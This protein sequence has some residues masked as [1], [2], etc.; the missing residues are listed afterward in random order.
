MKNQPKILDTF[1]IIGFAI[2]I[3]VSIGLILAKQNTISSVT[4]GFILAIFTQLFNLQIRHGDTEQ[5]LLRANLLSQ[6]LYQDEWLFS[7]L[8]QIVENYQLVRNGWFDFFR[9]R[10]KD[11]VVECRNLLHAMAEGYM[12]AHPRSPVDFGTEAAQMAEK[13]YKGTDTGDLEYWRS[14]HGERFFQSNLADAQRGVQVMRIFLQ[15]IDE[16]RKNIDLLEKQQAAGIEVRVAS[17]DELP[18]ELVQDY[19]IVDDRIFSVMT[20]SHDGF[21][22]EERISIDQV[23]VQGFVKK[24]D[25]LF[26]HSKS[27]DDAIDNLRLSS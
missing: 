3:T 26:Q 7:H 20:F 24:F 4:L 25:L 12:M 6:Q 16:L 8:Q 22:Q 18:P 27:L 19:L 13:C 17:R 11:A 15:T 9:L 14:A 5:R 21:P 1:Q 10:S 23:E 2:S